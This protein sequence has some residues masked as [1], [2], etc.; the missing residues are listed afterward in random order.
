[1]WASSD[2]S[3]VGGSVAWKYSA[4]ST[5][6]QIS[7]A[8]A[9]TR[10]AALTQDVLKSGEVEGADVKPKGRLALRLGANSAWILREQQP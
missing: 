9:G 7:P 6:L 2:M 5:D 10:L 1:M 3:S 4:S 8:E